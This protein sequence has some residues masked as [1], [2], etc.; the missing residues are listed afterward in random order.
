MEAFN[1]QEIKK[2]STVAQ[3]EAMRIKAIE[4]TKELIALYNAEALLG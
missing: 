2:G 1:N 3:F 4:T